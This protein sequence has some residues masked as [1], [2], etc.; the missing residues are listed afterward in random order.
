MVLLSTIFALGIGVYAIRYLPIIDFLPYAAG[1]SIPKQ[2]ERP[3]VK[4]DLQYVFLDKQNNKE[5]E[6]KEYLADTNKY[7]YV[8]SEVLNE[9]LIKPKITDY[10][11]T[12]TSGNDVT[13]QTFEGKVLLII[14]KKT[15]GLEELDFGPIIALG[16]KVSKEN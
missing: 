1:K 13:Q 14:L 3:D 5:I 6:S 9:D 10:S 4:P 8:S 7:K 11:I 2:M 15:E 16:N 12:D